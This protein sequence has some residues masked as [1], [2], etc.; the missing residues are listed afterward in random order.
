MSF[1]VMGADMQPQGQAQVIIN[2]VDHGLDVQAAG[3]SPRWHH[4]GS[5]Q[6]MGEDV[7]GL[8]PTGVLHLETGVPEATR[9]GLAELGWA[10]GP[11]DGAFGRYHAIELRHCGGKQVYA[12]ASEMRADGVALAY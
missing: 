4:T 6:T 10:L 5:P 3:D 2:R 7:P 1:G 8:G 11:S 9:R 12:A